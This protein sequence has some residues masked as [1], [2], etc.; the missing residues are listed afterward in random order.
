MP[1][2]KPGVIVF[3]ATGPTGTLVCQQLRSADIPVAAVLRSAHRTDEFE[4]L[5]IEV[6]NADAMQ[7]ETLEPVLDLT[8]DKYPILLN[9]LGGNPF[10]DPA[11]WPDFTGVAN[12]TQAAVLAGY[13]RYVLVTTIGTGDSWQYVPDTEGFLVPIIKLKDKA[14]RH[15]R[16]TALHWTILKPGGL[17]PPDYHHERGEALITENHGVRGLIDREDLAGVIVKVLA[18]HPDRVRHRELYAVV[19]QIEPHAGPPAAF[20]LS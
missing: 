9:L 1:D 7:P 11:G 12:V 16:Q 14:E 5:G 2:T 6:F 8:V 19:Q 17:G 3:G 20:I 4:A 15:L 18:A 13:Q 10:E